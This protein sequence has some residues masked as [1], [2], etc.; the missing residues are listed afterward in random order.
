VLVATRRDHPEV[1]FAVIVYVDAEKTATGPRTYYSVTYS[2]PAC[3][4]PHV[5]QLCPN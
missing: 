1:I 4:L 2:N 5:P 3:T